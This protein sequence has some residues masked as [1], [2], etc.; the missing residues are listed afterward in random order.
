MDRSEFKS[1]CYGIDDLN[2]DEN[3]VV[4]VTITFFDGLNYQIEA[5]D[6]HPIVEEELI[7]IYYKDEWLKLYLSD[8]KYISFG[9]VH[10]Y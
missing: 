1:I 5:K 10:T 2:D 8:I 4:G 3:V 7:Q 9:I 6:F